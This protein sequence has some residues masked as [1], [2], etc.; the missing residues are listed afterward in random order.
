MVGPVVVPSLG[1]KN[2]TE[3]PGAALVA[4]ELPPPPPQPAMASARS[5][6][7][8]APASVFGV[9]CILI[10]LRAGD[11]RLGTRRNGQRGSGTSRGVPWPGSS[12]PC[13]DVV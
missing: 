13:G 8:I 4:F 11:R 5:A 9:A 10:V 12:S 2:S 1:L 3:A 6:S 7:R